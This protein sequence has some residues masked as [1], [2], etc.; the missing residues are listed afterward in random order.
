MNICEQL[1]LPNAI[2][3]WT[4]VQ[5]FALMLREVFNALLKFH[6]Q[7]PQEFPGVENVRYK[8]HQATTVTVVLLPDFLFLSVCYRQ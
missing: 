6:S 2:L 8:K 7:E 4:S 1:P 3:M 5:Y